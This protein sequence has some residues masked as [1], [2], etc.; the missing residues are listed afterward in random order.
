MKQKV[1]VKIHQK[2][3]PEALLWA[4]VPKEEWKKAVTMKDNLNLVEKA[5]TGQSLE[6]AIAELKSEGKLTEADSVQ[7][8]M[9]RLV[10]ILEELDSQD[11]LEIS[12]EKTEETEQMKLE[13]LVEAENLLTNPP[14]AAVWDEAQ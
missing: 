9:D 3:Y 14:E 1:M 5:V 6:E 8:E 11:N 7:E 13:E 4:I 10:G 2:N 12:S